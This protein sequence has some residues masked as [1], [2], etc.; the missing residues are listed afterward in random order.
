MMM[1]G[2]QDEIHSVIKQHV[3]VQFPG[4]LNTLLFETNYTRQF[5]NIE[6]I[7]SF[8]LKSGLMRGFFIMFFFLIFILEAGTGQAEYQFDIVKMVIF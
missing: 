7:T 6:V 3:G 2:L 1:G 8:I 4:K 5:A